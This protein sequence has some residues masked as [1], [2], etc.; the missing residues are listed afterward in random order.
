MF[1]QTL[2]ATLKGPGL[3]WD[4]I[5]FAVDATRV[6]VA[7]MRRDGYKSPIVFLHGFG[8]TKEDYADIARYPIFDGHPV[9]AYDAPGCGATDCDTPSAIDIPFQQKTA[10]AVLAYFGFDRFHLV[11][12]SMGG[13]TALMLAHATRE[14]VLSFTNIEGNLGSEDCFLSRQTFEYGQDDAEHFFDAFIDRVCRSPGFANAVY[15]TGLR[16]KVRARAVAP[17][18]RSMVELS[19]HADLLQKFLALPCPKSFVFGDAH[20]SLSYLGQLRDNGV[21]LFEIPA[22]GHFPMYSNPPLMWLAISEF[23]NGIEG[24]IRR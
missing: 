13:L 23:I 12:H 11:G 20:R 19:D 6:G 4:R 3:E 7:V 21:A 18:F 9:I 15:A 16:G 5:E 10:Q 22:C 24:N 8:S 14:S 2:A 17:I 1:N